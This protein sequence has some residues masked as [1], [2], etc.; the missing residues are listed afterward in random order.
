MKEIDSFTLP[1]MSERKRELITAQHTKIKEAA[2]KATETVES[3]R[4]FA[5]SLGLLSPKQVDKI[6]KRT[7]PPHPIIVKTMEALH[8]QGPKIVNLKD[9][10][11]QTKQHLQRSRELLSR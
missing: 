2:E 9:A 10:I 8:K 1:Y 7:L 4:A 5:T 11:E 6:V 3:A